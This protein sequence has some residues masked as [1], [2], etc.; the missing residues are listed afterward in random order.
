MQLLRGRGAMRQAAEEA[1]RS[2]DMHIIDV[3]R[4]VKARRPDM[5]IAA[6]STSSDGMPLTTY[7][8]CDEQVTKG[9]SLMRFTA[10]V[11]VGNGN[12]VVRS[13]SRAVPS[14]Q[15]VRRRSIPRSSIAQHRA[16]LSP[17]PPPQVGWAKGK[18]PEV[19][20]AVDKAY[21]RAARS[22]FFFDRFEG[23]TIF[24]PTV[25]KF[26][27]TKVEI[28]PLPTG[29]GLRANGTV[30]KAGGPLHG[31]RL[32]AGDSRNA[33]RVASGEPLRSPYYLHSLRICPSQIRAVCEL[34][35]IKDL[36]AKVHG[37]HN[38]NST[39]RAIF[40]VR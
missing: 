10:L 31:I 23:H 16:Y 1:D 15:P 18:A 11:V 26:G 19:G 34:A 29:Y 17:I 36:R 24:H 2:L 40:E 20:S 28:A 6:M 3:N 5:T 4:T 30:R 37:S 12:G 33:Q 9:G 27:K 38:P 8:R 14:R 32:R 21:W 25:A 13:P 39:V 35:G 7:L 22:L